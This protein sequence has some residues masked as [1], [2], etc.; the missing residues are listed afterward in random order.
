M[1][2]DR[3]LIQSG[4]PVIEDRYVA[5]TMLIMGKDP[6]VVSATYKSSVSSVAELLDEQFF[7]LYPNP[8]SFEFYLA[9]TLQAESQI[10]I[11]LMDLSGRII[12]KSIKNF[13]LDAGPA[14]VN[15]PVQGMMPGAYLL[16][17]CINN[18]TYARLLNI[19]GIA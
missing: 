5:T 12:G 16:T 1:T 10:R 13:L 19:D 7:E 2:F 17:L 15:V 3:W 18:R 8:A 9:F 6:A 11:S 14:L 4:N